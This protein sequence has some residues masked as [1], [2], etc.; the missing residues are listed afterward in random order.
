MYAIIMLSLRMELTE[1]S[2]L[3]IHSESRIFCV[4]IS[5]IISLHPLVGLRPPFKITQLSYIG[6]H[7]LSSFLSFC[8]TMPAVSLPGPVAYTTPASVL[9]QCWCHNRSG[10]FR[11]SQGYIAQCG[12]HEILIQRCITVFFL[13]IFVDLSS[14]ASESSPFLRSKVDSR[15]F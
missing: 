3:I 7:S 8:L 14:T 5:S 13:S 11:S 6:S 1:R 15:R 2:V 4:V 9:S 10:Q 12:C